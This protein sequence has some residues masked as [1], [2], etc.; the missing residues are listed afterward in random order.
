WVLAWNT[1]PADAVDVAWVEIVVQPTRT[2]ALIIGN[3]NNTAAGQ[4]SWTAVRVDAS[5]TAFNAYALALSIQLGDA[6]RVSVRAFA[7]VMPRTDLVLPLPEAIAS[8]V[9]VLGSDAP[10]PY[11]SRW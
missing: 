4:T 1:A 10:T 11:P 3:T 8:P 9:F 6:E 2:S 5:P 7:D